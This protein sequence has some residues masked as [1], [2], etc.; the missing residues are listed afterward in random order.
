MNINPEWKINP[1]L[2]HEIETLLQQKN[3][4]RAQVKLQSLLEELD[5]L[6]NRL[7]QTAHMLEERSKE[8]FNLYQI[9]EWIIRDDISENNF[10]Q[11]LIQIIPDAWQYPEITC[12]RIIINE[13]E[14][15][16]EHFRRTAW[17][18]SDEIMI[19]NQ[20]IG[21][22]EVCYLEERPEEY[23]GPFLQEELALLNAIARKAGLFLE[24]KKNARELHES[25]ENL[26]VILQSL[27]D[28]VIA[29]DT[30]G[31]I[32]Q[33]NPVAENLTGWKLSEAKD[34]KIE[35]VF[36]IVNTFSGE[37]VV[38]PVSLVLQSGQ[39]AHLANQT[40]LIS[41]TGQEYQIADSG[42]PITDKEGNVTGVVLVFRDVTKDF[43]LQQKL[44]ESEKRWQFALEG[45]GE[46]VWDWDITTGKVFYSDQ[47]KKMLGHEPHEIKKSYQEWESRI[48][49][50]DLTQTLN[51]LQQQLASPP[52][53]YS[54]KHRMRCKDG[55]YIWVL[56]RGKVVTI[57]ENGKPERIVGTSTDITKQIEMEE[58]IRESEKKY[59]HITENFSDIVWRTDLNFKTT[60]ISPS[61]KWIFNETPEEHLKKEV[62]DK[63]PP[64]AQEQIQR[65]VVEELQKEKQGNTDLNRS[66]KVELQHY[67]ND[68]SLIWVEMNVSYIR[69]E[70]GNITGFQGVTRDISKRKKAEIEL[71]NKMEEM[72]RFNRAMVGRENKM[73]E[74]KKEINEL[75][76]K[77][78]QA[79]K[80]R[81][82]D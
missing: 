41:K 38:N 57:S 66:R 52:H 71:K 45:S 68:G 15:K 51:T 56:D 19:Q 58:K 27:G 63:F 76:E 36:H 35:D 16:S 33:M 4:E 50:E 65:I 18:Q 21:K 31:I 40:K 81:I 80:Y 24:R 48:H 39:I 13:R 60:Y 49:P 64:D 3:D 9:S 8:L 37:K 43:K 53:I 54:S 72:E 17:I 70:Q 11:K 62:K 77:A 25:H 46:G 47:W 75:L 29:T 26:K 73:I 34:K 69:D 2:I 5:F 20:S 30:R 14:F 10:F 44:K 28:A 12:A 55:A 23:K 74:L 1:T 82:P 59:R 6:Q 7:Q 78:G 79:K 42:A 32:K 22:I 61:I 67:K